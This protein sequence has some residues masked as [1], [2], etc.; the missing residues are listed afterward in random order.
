MKRNNLSIFDDGTITFN[1]FDQIK[2]DQM[3]TVKIFDD[4]KVV[5]AFDIPANKLECHNVIRV[6]AHKCYD[7]ALASKLIEV[8]LKTDTYFIYGDDAYYISQ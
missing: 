1:G 8:G 7:P 2:D 3:L 4:R 5:I 6:S